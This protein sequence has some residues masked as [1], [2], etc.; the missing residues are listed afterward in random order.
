VTEVQPLF[1]EAA[2]RLMAQHA[3]VRPGRM[4]ASDGLRTGDKFFAMVS[5]GDL[6][7]RL[8]EDRVGELTASEDATAFEV[9]GRRMREWVRVTPPDAQACEGLMEEARDFVKA[10]SRS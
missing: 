2:D 10:Q 6:V 4:F 5:K 1:D 9:G 3:D 7:L 8:P